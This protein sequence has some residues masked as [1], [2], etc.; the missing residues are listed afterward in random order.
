MNKTF[1]YNMFQ[2][3]FSRA[4]ISDSKE[5]E[6]WA[7]F[8]I[9]PDILGCLNVYPSDFS[10]AGSIADPSLTSLAISDP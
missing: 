3:Y 7:I 10:F 5:E 6:F 8:S 1:V 2:V 4:E 9:A